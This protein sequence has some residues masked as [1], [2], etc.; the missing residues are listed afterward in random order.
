MKVKVVSKFIDKETKKVRK[1]GE[2]FS[3][4]EKRYDEILQVGNFVVK[5]EEKEKKKPVKKSE[6]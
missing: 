3:C 2:E 6:E 1:V 4:T 5:V